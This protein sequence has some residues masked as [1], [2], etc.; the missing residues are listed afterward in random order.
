MHYMKIVVLIVFLGCLLEE[1]VVEQDEDV[2]DTWF[3]SAIYPFAVWG[4][5]DNTE[6][7]QKY[8]RHKKYW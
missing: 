3:S 2:L 4:W 7:L 8:V 1:L 5:P 6:D